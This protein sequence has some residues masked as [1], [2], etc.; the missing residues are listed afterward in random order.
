MADTTT[1]SAADEFKA[2]VDTLR[3]AAEHAR[4]TPLSQ[5]RLVRA[6][7]DPVADWL[8]TWSSVDFREDGP[9]A[10]DFTHALRIV[11]VINGGS[12]HV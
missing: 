12:D 4:S 9:M 6:L 3:E 11:R 2:A 8:E 1:K 7:A 5:D 10:E